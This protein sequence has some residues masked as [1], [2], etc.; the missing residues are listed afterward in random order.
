MSFPDHLRETLVAQAKAVREQMKR[1][2]FLPTYLYKLED[3]DHG[4]S[5]VECTYRLTYQVSPWQENGRTLYDVDVLD[6]RLESAVAF[7]GKHGV[8]VPCGDADFC[9]DAVREFWRQYNAC[10]LRGLE[11][12]LG[13]DYERGCEAAREAHAM[14]DG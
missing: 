5:Y 13:D 1:N 10:L 6:C 14:G 9:E 11:G 12:E 4:T 8:D 2:T 3:T 7:I